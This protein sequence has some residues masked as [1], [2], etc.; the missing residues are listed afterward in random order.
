M[1]E[2]IREKWLSWGGGIKACT[3]KGKCHLQRGEN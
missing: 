3:L 1:M 2:D